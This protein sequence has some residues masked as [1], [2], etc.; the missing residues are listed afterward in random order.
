MPMT[1][2]KKML[3]DAAIEANVNIRIIEERHAA[4]DHPV[5]LAVPETDYLKFILIQVI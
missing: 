5:L 2:F 1:E 3:L 4:Y